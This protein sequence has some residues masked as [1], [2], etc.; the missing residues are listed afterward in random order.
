MK[1]KLQYRTLE[2]CNLQVREAAAED[3]NLYIEGY[4]SVFD[5]KYYFSSDE[6]ETID[7]HAFDSALSRPDDVRALINHD[8]TLVLG[9]TTV[10]TLTLS[11]DDHG[12]HGCITINRED[13]DAMNLYSRVQRG[14][15][16]QCSFGFIPLDIETEVERE[17]DHDIIH[18]T[19]KDLRLY[20]V[21]VCTFPAYVGTEVSARSELYEES[22]KKIRKI[23]ADGLLERVHKL[24]TNKEDEE[25][26]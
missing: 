21:T 14:D 4:F 23:W 12:L 22:L 17:N 2:M 20:E 8:T 26:A 3:K 11:V 19:I 25:N 1:D 6:Y 24:T 10:G 16:S 15:V 13:R 5:Q 7:R 9:R 18:Y